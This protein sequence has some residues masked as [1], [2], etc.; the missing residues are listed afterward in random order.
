MLSRLFSACKEKGE[1]K[2]VNR[3]G[4]G[5]ESQAVKRQNK[6]EGLGPF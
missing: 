1:L 4:Y 2:E 5:L 6:Q 3:R